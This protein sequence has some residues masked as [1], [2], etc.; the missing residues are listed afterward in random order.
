LGSKNSSVVADGILYLRSATLLGSIYH[1]P[2][3]FEFLEIHLPRIRAGKSVSDAELGRSG[4]IQS[5]HSCF[6]CNYVFTKKK[7]KKMKKKCKY[8]IA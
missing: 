2:L 6:S 8:I 1:Y 7:C 3:R 5:I 4:V